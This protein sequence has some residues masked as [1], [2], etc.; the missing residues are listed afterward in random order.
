MTRIRT[1]LAA[2]AAVVVSALALASSPA[3][4]AGTTNYIENMSGINIGVMHLFDGDYTNTWYDQLL[5]AQRRSDRIFP[6]WSQTQGFYIG[7]GYC[8]EMWVKNQYTDG[9]VHQTQRIKGGYQQPTDPAY[10]WRVRA[11][12]TPSSG[13]C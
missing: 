3:Q 2:G 7:P 6:T 1:R 11:Y 12:P 5:P 4:A 8:A 10:D 9:W 13:N